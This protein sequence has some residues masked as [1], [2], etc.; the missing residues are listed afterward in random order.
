MLDGLGN[1][2]AVLAQSISSL[3]LDLQGT[4]GLGGGP[5]KEKKK[6]ISHLH[7]V[8][9]EDTLLRPN[10]HMCP[11]SVVGQGGKHTQ[12]EKETSTYMGDQVLFSVAGEIDEDSCVR[13]DAS[14]ENHFPLQI[15]GKSNDLCMK[16]SRE[17]R[18]LVFITLIGL[19][20]PLKSKQVFGG[21]VSQARKPV[22]YG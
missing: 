3:C 20:S 1:R 17:A 13:S 21:G 14:N 9:P 6:K 10:G 11:L 4:R 22:P 5:E 7:V 8:S 15:D 16:T 2:L 19:A 12:R 18:H